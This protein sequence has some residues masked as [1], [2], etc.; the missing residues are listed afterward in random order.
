MSR[1]ALVS[2]ALAAVTACVAAPPAVAKLPPGTAFE[3]CGESG[4]RTTTGDEALE[5]SGL[6]IE[7]ASEHGDS[8]APVGAAEWLQVDIVFPA[9][10]GEPWTPQ[11]LDPIDR[12]FPVVFVPEA[13]SVGAPGIGG[14][15]RWVSP[16]FRVTSAYADVTDGVQ[17]FPTQVLAELD[18]HAVAGSGT[19]GASASTDDGEGAVPAL[20]IAAAAA[21]VL[22]L[23]GALAYGGTR[24]RRKA[25]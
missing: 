23:A 16:R 1:R 20:L 25:A 18:P 22:L 2:V 11:I 8:S 4:C 7:A 12:R 6:L 3:A 19:D 21:V 9:D 14:V 24:L 5:L 15:Y 17:P 10:L 13:K